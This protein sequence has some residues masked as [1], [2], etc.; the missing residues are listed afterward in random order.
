M[1]KHWIICLLVFVLGVLSG[2]F[3]VLSNNKNNS[4]S[5]FNS[6]INSLT[7]PSGFDIVDTSEQMRPKLSCSIPVSENRGQTGSND[8]QPYMS[9]GSSKL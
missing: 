1:S 7:I 3:Y 5:S 6:E 9:E 2:G 4:S 8:V